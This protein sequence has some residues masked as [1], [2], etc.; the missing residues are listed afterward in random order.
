MTLF[1]CLV[2]VLVNCAEF[3]GIRGVEG[4]E[5]EELHKECCVRTPGEYA[6]GPQLAS[7]V[8]E[9]IL[10]LCSRLKIEA[11]ATVDALSPPDFALNSVLGRADGRLANAL[12]VLS[13]TAEDGE[14]E[15]RVHFL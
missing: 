4:S 5:E 6:S 9:G 11:V 10:H 7:L 12:V 15:V 13:S 3:A 1:T 14:I 8:G 2:L